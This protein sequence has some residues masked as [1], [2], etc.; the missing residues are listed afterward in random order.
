[1]ACPICNDTRWKS[2]DDDG[3]ERVVRCDCW[4]D[5][6]VDRLVEAARIPARFAKAELETYRA[7]TDSPH[8]ALAKAMRFVDTFPVVDRG[9]LFH[10]PVGVGK[11]HL[12]VGIL[13]A[14]I[15]KTGAK[16]YFFETP[17]LLRQ[18]RNTYN[19]RV[20]ETEMGVLQP[21]IDAELLVLD[22][23]G[24]EKT[25]EWVQ[26]TLGLVIN[27][28]YN[29]RRPTIITTNLQD[30]N[31][32]TNPNSFMFQIGARTRSR[33][34][35]MCEWI[36]IEGADERDKDREAAAARSGQWPDP[37]DNIKKAGLPGRTRGQARAQ[38]RDKGSA[39]LKWTGGK[40]GT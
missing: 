15:R 23:L 36:Q 31:D 14:V 25:S 12:A 29:A 1:M 2:I 16:G 40:A 21:V 4:R 37:P 9:M 26:E 20:D 11:T 10:G 32:S 30:D 18:V 35:E 5:A 39:E 19:T 13:K 22:D 8:A 7:V 38:M 27:S 6:L 17:D 3:V 28:R 33:L 34:V 24:A